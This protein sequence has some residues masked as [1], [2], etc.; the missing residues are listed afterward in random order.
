MMGS[1]F[2]FSF[3]ALII[4]IIH[5]MKAARFTSGMSIASIIVAPSITDIPK[6]AMNSTSAC[7]VWNF[8]RVLFFIFSST[9]YQ[10]TPMSI[11]Y[12]SIAQIFSF[13]TFAMGS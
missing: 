2:C 10:M 5:S 8:A 11:T 7:L 13:S 6:L 3:A 4:P 9:K 12:D 1:S